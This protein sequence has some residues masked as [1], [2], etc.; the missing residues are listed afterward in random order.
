MEI[1]GYKDRKSDY[2]WGFN[3]N[4]TMRSSL[5]VVMMTGM[6]PSLISIIQFIMVYV[7]E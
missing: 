1:S 4:A 3:R 2:R 5:A 6:N 7:F